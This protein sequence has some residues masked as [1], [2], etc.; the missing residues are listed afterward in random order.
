MTAVGDR[1]ALGDLPIGKRKRA[2]WRAFKRW[3]DDPRL[4][5]WRMDQMTRAMANSL[6]RL[7]IGDFKRNI[8]EDLIIGLAGAV[9]VEDLEW[10]SISGSIQISK[11]Q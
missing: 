9:A 3:P 11:E 7:L 2:T 10:R 5:G 8:S 1:G 6:N 4:I